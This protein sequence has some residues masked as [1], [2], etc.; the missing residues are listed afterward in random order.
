MIKDRMDITGARWST[1]GAQAVL[2]LRAVSSNGDLDAY[3]AF[4]QQQELRRNHLDHYQERF[5]LVA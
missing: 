1:E 5:D 4:H 3:W 2:A